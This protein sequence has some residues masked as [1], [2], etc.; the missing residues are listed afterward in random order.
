MDEVYN[1][2][3]D[4]SKHGCRID[5]LGHLTY[6]VRYMKRAGKDI[7]IKK[8]Y[9]DISQIYKRLIENDIAL[10]INTSGIRQGAGMTFPDEGLLRLYY[11]AGGR[12]ITVGS[13]AHYSKD[14]GADIDT[15]LGMARNIG[16]RYVRFRG[17]ESEMNVRID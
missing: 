4:K 11:D 7:D 15:A 14:I 6:P 10:E 12:A 9:A 3:L 16:F 8:Y 13:D 5:T 1:L 17:E 2:L